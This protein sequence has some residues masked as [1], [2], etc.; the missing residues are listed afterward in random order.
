MLH[1]RLAA[2]LKV[3]SLPTVLAVVNRKMVASFVGARSEEEVAQWVDKWYSAAEAEAAGG[4]AAAGQAG[5]AGAK[6][7]AGG[8]AAGKKE[9]AAQQKQLEA[10]LEPVLK[11]AHTHLITQGPMSAQELAGAKNVF[12][13]IL[14][15]KDAA[16]FHPRATAGLGTCVYAWRF[17]KYVRV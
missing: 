12:T 5:A 2:S 15:E 4:G 8:A 14:A 16:V 7:G 9:A 17:T 11:A 3:Q 1:F 6:P 10:Q 13:Q